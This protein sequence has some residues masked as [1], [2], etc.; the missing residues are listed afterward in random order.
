MTR[1]LASLAAAS[2]LLL[3]LVGAAAWATSHARPLGWRLI[4]TAHS[5]DLT[6]VDRG[7]RTARFTTAAHASDATRPGFWDAWWASS[8]SGRLML[9]AQVVDYEGAMRRVV[10]S[11]PSLIVE[12]SGRTR[13]QAVVFGRMPIDGPPSSGLGF[14]LHADARLVD[15]AHGPVSARAWLVAL[16]YWCIVLLGL[17]LPLRWLRVARRRD[18]S[19]P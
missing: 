1:R 7:R 6:R 16:P 19:S 15:G 11:P 3:S 10:A 9:L 17:P 2:S 13:A 8:R 5:A 12:P 14:A 18:G 4:G